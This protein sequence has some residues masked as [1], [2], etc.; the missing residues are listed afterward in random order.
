M[1][2]GQ[3]IDPGPSQW[4]VGAV[5]TLSQPYSKIDDEHDNDSNNKKPHDLAMLLLPLQ[6]IEHE[7]A[8]AF[9]TCIHIARTR[10]Q[11]AH[12]SSRRGNSQQDFRAK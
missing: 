9:F 10:V 6:F 11:I 12:Y 7:Q 2:M 4:K 3:E 1:T 8:L 5:T